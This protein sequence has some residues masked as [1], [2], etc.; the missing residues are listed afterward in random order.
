MKPALG[1]ILTLAIVSRAF[2]QEPCSN[3]RSSQT[4]QAVQVWTKYPVYGT[5]SGW[6]YGTVTDT[7]QQGASIEICEQ[8]SIG[9]PGSTQLWLRIRWSGHEGWIYGDGTVA[10]ASW[11]HGVYLLLVGFK[12][13]PPS[14]PQLE[15]PKLPSPPN[16]VGWFVAC[17]IIGVIVYT[18]IDEFI[19]AKKTPVRMLAIKSVLPL[20]LAPGAFYGLTTHV[21][22]SLTDASAAWTLYLFAFE[23]GALFAHFAAWTEHMGRTLGAQQRRA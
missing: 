21:E 9:V 15:V 19:S 7:L 17:G 23:N 2:S 1:I 5:N 22:V 6:S 18:L 11:T 8:R 13:V 12:P 10:L 20:I 4:R 14:V 16:P 3:P